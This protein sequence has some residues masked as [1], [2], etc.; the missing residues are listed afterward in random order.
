VALLHTSLA[1]YGQELNAVVQRS[2]RPS[3]AHSSSGITV[4]P[5]WQLP[6]KQL[7]RVTEPDPQT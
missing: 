4:L 6:P 7:G 2:R 3:S 1:G 5:Q